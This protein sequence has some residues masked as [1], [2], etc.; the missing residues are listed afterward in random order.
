MQLSVT[1]RAVV[2]LGL[3]AYFVSRIWVAFHKWQDGKIGKLFNNLEPDLV[4]VKIININSI[5]I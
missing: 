5:N 1:I 2:L 3:F 4:Q